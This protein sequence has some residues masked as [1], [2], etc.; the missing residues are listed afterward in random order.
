MAKSTTTRTRNGPPGTIVRASGKDGPQRVAS[1][2]ARWTDEAEA[3]FL[4]HLAASCNV[5]ASAASAGFSKEA[6]Y[7]RRRTDPDFADRW[8]AAL[9]QGYVRL[10]MMLLHGATG[11]AD[12]AAD[13]ADRA[14]PLTNNLKCA[15]AP[16]NV[17]LTARAT[18]LDKDSVANVSLVVALDKDQLIERAK[19]T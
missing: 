16:G 4:D 2:G 7:R 12:P 11:R 9:E 8:Q 17:A 5:T 19:P 3:L 18:G 10:E 15:D 1:T 6:L 14:E 13:P